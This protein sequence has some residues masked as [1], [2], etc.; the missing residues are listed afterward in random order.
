M[1]NLSAGV[2][3]QM[4]KIHLDYSESASIFLTGVL[5]FCSYIHSGGCLSAWA[6]RAISTGSAAPSSWSA[7]P[8]CISRPN[9]AHEAVTSSLEYNV[10][11]TCAVGGPAVSC[12]PWTPRWWL[13][14]VQNYAESISAST[15]IRPCSRARSSCTSRWGTFQIRFQDCKHFD[16]TRSKERHRRSSVK[17]I[18][19]DRWHR[20]GWTS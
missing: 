4:K 9:E 14:A 20:D 6:I 13:P 17:F 8:S 16:W 19:A 5:T 7:H 3:L 18:W 10:R 2:K 12:H 1:S 11:R 15:T